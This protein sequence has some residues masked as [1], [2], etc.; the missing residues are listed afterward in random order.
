MKN[1]FEFE[2]IYSKYSV[3]FLA[4]YLLHVIGYFI[5]SD[6]YNKFLIFATIAGSLYLIVSVL[7]ELR[8]HWLEN[9]KHGG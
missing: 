3:T 6:S 4:L 1:K 2:I 7:I 5:A 8:K 9:K